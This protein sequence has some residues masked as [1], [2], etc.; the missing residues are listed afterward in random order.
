MSEIN[1][2][3]APEAHVDDV[4][5]TP[6]NSGFIPT[7]RAV[8]AGQGWEWIAS[9]YRLFKR[10]PFL[11]IGILVVTFVIFFALALVPLLGSLATMLL[12]PVFGAGIIIG[13]KALDEGGELEFAHLFAGFKR[14][15]GNLIVVGLL[16]LI[17]LFVTA[18][19]AIAIAGVAFLKM[20]TG[21]GGDPAVLVGQSLGTFMIAWLVWMALLI[22]VIM[23]YWFAPALVALNDLAPVEALK[24]SFFACLKN[25]IPFLLYGVIL[26]VLGVLALI[27]F[28]LGFLVLGPVLVASIYTAYRDIFFEG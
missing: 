22:P 26:L 15:T 20:F 14:N 1:P 27:P 19:P 21:M 7:G 25:I 12:S 23:A 6:D 10:Q 8:D 9:G 17:A 11:W 18:I 4:A 3:R 5:V 2:Y 16:Y 28:A 13:C 24:T